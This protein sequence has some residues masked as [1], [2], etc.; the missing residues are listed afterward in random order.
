[1][2]TGYGSEAVMLFFIVSG[3]SIHYSAKASVFNVKNLLL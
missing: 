1:V 2:L 3:F